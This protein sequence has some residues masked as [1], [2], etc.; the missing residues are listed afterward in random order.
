MRRRRV[1]KS[2]RAFRQLGIEV[3]KYHLFM[4]QNRLCTS[5]GIKNKRAVVVQVMNV[6]KVYSAYQILWLSPCDKMA[7]NWVLW[8]F[9]K[10][11]KFHFIT[12][13]LSPCDNYQP[14]TIFWPCPEVVTISDNY[15]TTSAR[16]FFFPLLDYVA[17]SEAVQCL[18]SEMWILTLFQVV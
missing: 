10:C 3:M 4:R 16:L 8:L 6:N 9:F 2:S 17:M 11:P 14:V 5:S 12:L 13:E 7:Q 1:M 15:C 18:L